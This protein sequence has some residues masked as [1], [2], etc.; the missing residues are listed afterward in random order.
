MLAFGRH[1][2]LALVEAVEAINKEAEAVVAAAQAAA[3][4]VA[5]ARAAEDEERRAAQAAAE[6]AAAQRE[7]QERAAAAKAG[8]DK[9]AAEDA[10]AQAEKERN[11]RLAQELEQRRQ[12]E[13]SVVRS[14]FVAHYVVL[15]WA[16][17][18]HGCAQAEERERRARDEAQRREAAAQQ[19]AAQATAQA[20]REAE[21]KRQQRLAKAAELIA[22]TN[23]TAVCTPDGVCT[24][25][26]GGI[27]AA[28]PPSSAVSAPVPAPAPAPAPRFPTGRVHVLQSP[29]ALK[30]ALDSTKGVVRANL[31]WQ[32]A[33]RCWSAPVCSCWQGGWVLAQVVVD[34]FAHWCRPCHMLVRQNECDGWLRPRCSSR[35][36][37]SCSRRLF[38][39]S[40]P[41]STPACFS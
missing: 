21:E 18:I 40:S 1:Q 15:T 30:S 29:A 28:A 39:T 20:R 6:A 14:V 19:A 25:P 4:E 3:A 33:C 22:K 16:V 34:F 5:A 13:V 12:A 38:S 9:K 2:V 17:C 27:V 31:V 35:A 26:G 7:A 32:C 11:R 10:A 41:H 24:V 37:R 8:A 23:P 36:C